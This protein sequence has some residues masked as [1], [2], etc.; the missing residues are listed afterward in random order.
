MSRV[1]PGNEPRRNRTG[2]AAGRIL[3]ALFGLIASMGPAVSEDTKDWITALAREPIH[4]EAWPGGKKVAI[5]FV[6]YVE[7]WGY[8]HGPT[9]RWD[10]AGR[11]PDIVD[12]SFRQYAV[13]WGIPRVGRLFNEQ[14]VPL[15]IALNA[16]FPA[17]YPDVWKQFRSLVPKAPIIAHGINNSTQLL[18]LGRGIDAQAV[19]IRQ[20]LD[21]IE[22]DTGVRSSGW[23]SPSVYPNGDTFT[24]TA[25]EGIR[26]SLDG[27]DSDTLSRLSTKSG[28]LVL[29]PYPAVTVDMGQYLS[30]SKEPSDIER[31]WV[32]YVSELVREAEADP[33]REATVVA[34]GIH[35]F[36]IGTPA[37]AAALRRVL[38]NLKKQ[39]L[40]WMTDVQAVLSATGEKR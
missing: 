7:V 9:F 36:V 6:L 27:M 20:T 30:R 16:L 15:S 10:M 33:G 34:I 5:C 2:F 11:D 4:I 14:Q 28:P 13:Y 29:I 3:L 32:D 17:Q 25:G 1:G 21:M 31:L 22:K 39:K 12:E 8:G 38:E 24:A 37:G 18:P 23:S 40:V 26:Y 35:P 19:Y